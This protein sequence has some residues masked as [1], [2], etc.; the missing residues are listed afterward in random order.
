[1]IFEN[2]FL[3]HAG[4]I[5]VVLKA[6]GLGVVIIGWFTSAKYWEDLVE[7]ASN[8]SCDLW[9]VGVFVNLV[10]S[11]MMIIAPACID[12]HVGFVGGIIFSLLLDL[13]I[14]LVWLAV[15][16]L[17]MFINKVCKAREHIRRKRRG[18]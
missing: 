3:Y 13:L 9:L 15:W 2:L 16:L 4:L 11:T 5:W 10:I 14:A 18:Y 1:M 8:S 7:Y 6:L 17:I 12:G